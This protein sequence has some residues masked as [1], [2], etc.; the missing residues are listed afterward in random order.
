MRNN[1][2]GLNRLSQADL[3]CEDAP[4]FAK[5]SKRKNHRV[6]LVGVGIDT[7]LALRRRISLALV[8]T[9]NPNEILGE[10]PLVEGMHGR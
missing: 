1:Q 6:N 10:N 4:A 7:R 5:A 9:A 2:S 8:R 3:V